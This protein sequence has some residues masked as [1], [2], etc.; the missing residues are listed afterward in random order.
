MQEGRRIRRRDGARRWRLLQDV[1][2]PELWV[3]RFQSPTWLDHL[4]QHHRVTV[5]NRA[6]EERAL[7]FHAGSGRPQVRH[8]LERPPS[9][10]SVLGDTASPE[11]QDQAFVT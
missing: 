7:G 4:R 3:E 1:A 2:E 5:A 11:E 10:V 9:A 8:I 6:V